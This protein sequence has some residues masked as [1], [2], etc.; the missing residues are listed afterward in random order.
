MIGRYTTRA[1]FHGI[2]D[3]Y[4]TLSLCFC[5]SPGG[6]G[7]MASINGVK[8]GLIVLRGHLTGKAGGRKTPVSC[9]GQGLQIPA[10]YNIL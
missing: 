10:I 1:V 3:R 2:M 4:I 6:P 8:S 5:N 7:A 9:S